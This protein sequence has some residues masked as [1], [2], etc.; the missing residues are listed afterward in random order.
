M[1]FNDD[2]HCH[3]RRQVGSRSKKIV[4]A[5]RIEKLLVA[6][7]AN[8]YY[9]ANNMVAVDTRGD[10][11]DKDFGEGQMLMAGRMAVLLELGR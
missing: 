2:N 1:R 5:P 9:L 3:R 7:C 8:N 11:H 4:I 6:H 10:D